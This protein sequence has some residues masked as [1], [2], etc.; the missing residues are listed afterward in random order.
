MPSQYATF[1][2]RPRDEL[3]AL[4]FGIVRS[5]RGS[6]YNCSQETINWATQFHYGH[7]GE[8]ISARHAVEEIVRQNDLR[9]RSTSSERDAIHRL[10]AAINWSE[11]N[12]WGPDLVIKAF[13]DLDRIFFCGRLRGI[14]KVKWKR[15]LHSPHMAGICK[16]DQDRP[17]SG[18][19]E[20]WLN[21][22]KI[23]RTREH[24]PF[25]EMWAT[26]LHEMW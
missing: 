17:N 1:V 24:R 5:N 13:L 22:D 19:R 23:L 4:A 6:Y 12:R 8:Y 26:I 10:R 15:N 20:I 25:Q 14:V 3:Y 21:A 7:S 2:T 11:R 18:R 16:K 9:R